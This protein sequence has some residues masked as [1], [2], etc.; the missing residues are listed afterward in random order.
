[1][2]NLGFAGGGGLEKGFWR[3]LGERLSHVISYISSIYA[4]LRASSNSGGG[5]LASGEGEFIEGPMCFVVGAREVLSY[6]VV[7]ANIE[8]DD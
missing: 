6:K 7:A 8:S 5:G 1:M 3:D 4:E 2:G